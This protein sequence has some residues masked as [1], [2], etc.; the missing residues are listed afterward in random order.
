[1]EDQTQALQEAQVS[2]P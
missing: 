2:F 1:M